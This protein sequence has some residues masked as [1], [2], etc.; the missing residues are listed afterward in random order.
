M[1][2]VPVLSQCQ[3]QGLEEGDADTAEEGSESSTRKRGPARESEESVN[4]P[5]IK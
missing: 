3:C 4:G 5:K 1:R 2:F